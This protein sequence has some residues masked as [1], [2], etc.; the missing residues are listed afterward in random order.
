MPDAHTN[1]AKSLVATAPSPALSG[2][3]LVVTAGDGALFPTPPF[4]AVVFPPGAPQPLRG[5]AEIV[6]VTGVSTDTFTIVR[7]TSTDNNNQAQSIGVGWIIDASI[8]AK[9]LQDVETQPGT[10]LATSVYRPSSLDSWNVV[11]GTMTAMNF[12]S[13]GNAAS[14]S[15]TVPANGIIDVYFQ[16][17][18]TLI[19]A[20]VNTALFVG[21][22]QHGT[23]T[24][25]GDWINVMVNTQTSAQ[26]ILNV[27]DIFHV[28]GL[29]PGALQ[30]DLAAAYVTATGASAI[31]YAEGQHAALTTSHVAPL[32]VQVRASV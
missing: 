13:G 3:S 11:G 24:V 6:R 16:F 2:T 30:I 28:T 9:T 7:N 15:F 20:A 29:S 32:V 8:T 25:L 1:F 10:I 22:F 5:N 4:N 18:F 26:L 21:L 27:S 17:T 19:K 31:I 12:T 23:S 14:P